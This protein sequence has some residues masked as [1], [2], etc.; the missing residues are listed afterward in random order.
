MYD[1]CVLQCHWNV[2]AT[3]GFVL[4]VKQDIPG[5]PWFKKNLCHSGV[6]WCHGDSSQRPYGGIQKI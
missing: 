5:A 2:E 6:A 3:L 4:F 1:V